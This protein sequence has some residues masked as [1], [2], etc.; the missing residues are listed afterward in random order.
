MI[1]ERGAASISPL[2]CLAF[3]W[4]YTLSPHDS[5]TV[6]EDVW[7][8]IFFGKEVLPEIQRKVDHLEWA[9]QTVEGMRREAESV[10][11]SPPQVPIERIGWRHDFYS[12]DT[13][14]HLLYNPNNPDK[15]LDPWDGTW[16]SSDAQ[17]RAWALLTHERTFRIMR[18]LGFL[19]ALTGD[20]RYAQ[21][22]AEGMRSAVEM[23]ARND[24]RE[25]NNTDALYFQPLYDAQILML[26]ADSYDLTRDSDTYTEDD[27]R[28]I[29]SGIFETAIPYQIR[30]F[31]K[32]GA[33][34]MTCYVAAALAKVGKIAGRD[35]WR[36]M[37]LRNERGGLA[38]LLRTG[39]R[40]DENGKTD[41][42][43]FE[44]TMF[45]HFYSLCPLVTL[46]ELAR[47]DMSEAER[48]EL[49]PRFAALFAAPAA[50]A[51]EH[52]RLPTLGDLGAPKVMTLRSYRHVYEYATGR[53]D[54]EAYS[55][56]LAQIY[57]DGTPRNSLTALAYGRD[58]LPATTQLPHRSVILPAH[59]IAVF[60]DPDAGLQ[61]LFKAG[62]HGA[63]HD[64]PDKLHVS[65]SAYGRLAAADLGTAGYAVRHLHSYYRSTLSHNTLFVD[66]AD[67]QKVTSAHLDFKP[68]AVPAYAHRQLD[69]AYDGVKLN[70]ELFFEP[71]FLVL[72]DA[73]ASHEEHRYGWVF[74]AYGS[75][76]TCASSEI[77]SL[78]L[79]PLPDNGAWKHFSNRSVVCAD[80]QLIADWR[81]ADGIWLRLIVVSD[82]PMEAVSARTP[83]NPRPDDQ[84]AVVLRV[85]GA[86][87]RFFA[88]F[89]AHRGSPMLQDLTVD[90]ER[91]IVLATTTNGPVEI[92]PYQ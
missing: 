48:A 25:G 67:Q 4:P 24:L 29:L 51:D 66:E 6:I 43:W 9:R 41:G 82:G 22:V 72:A 1:Q 42:F 83:G 56:L 34:N 89:E 79:P 73:C 21:W 17:R 46:W 12:H 60:R 32:S 39:L 40:D 84:G 92:G 33:H 68:D 90:A 63:G 35:D 61:V 28:A 88:A 54:P 18:S 71:P 69:D 86:K 15:H 5:G 16:H 64:H 7:P 26:L 57:A 45:Y 49:E 44:G 87:R 77:G 30:F 59:G 78:G 47:E 13:G 38:A 85:A 91:R 37:G 76:S 8:T 55:P 65:L 62:P 20:E 70:R 53:V 50:L 36:N 74:H 58:M 14:E 81:V 11:S 10:L 3:G 2:L 80:E 52:L 27:H 31:E 23:F 19:Y 75:L